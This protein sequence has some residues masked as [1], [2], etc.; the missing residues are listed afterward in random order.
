MLI[1]YIHVCT[2]MSIFIHAFHSVVQ[3]FTQSCSFVYSR[4]GF[5]SVCSSGVRSRRS[6]VCSLTYSFGCPSTHSTIR[7]LILLLSDSIAFFFFAFFVQFF[8]RLLDL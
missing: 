4:G 6:T 2:K 7:S 1:K 3:L 5:L 8:L